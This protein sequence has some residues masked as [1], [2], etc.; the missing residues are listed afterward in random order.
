MPTRAGLAFVGLLLLLLLAGI[1]YQNSLAYGLCFLLASLFHTTI[2]HTFTNLLGL[3]VESLANPPVF[4]GEQ[5]GFALRLVASKRNFC[6][7][8]LSFTED[9]T[10][11]DVA[12]GGEQRLHL[13]LP[14]TQRGWL[15]PGRLKVETR[16][17][18]GLLK[19]WSWLDLDQRVLVYPQPIKGDWQ[20][21]LGITPDPGEGRSLH[22]LGVDDFHELRRYQA[23]DSLQRVHWKAYSK[24]QGLQV[25]EFAAQAGH[26]Q[27]LDFSALSGSVEQRLSVL[28]Q[29]VLDLE[30]AERSYGLRLPGFELAQGQGVAQQEAALKALALFGISD[31]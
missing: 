10:R 2:L 1:N 16:Y 24:G 25:K 30:A 17:P 9:Q 23:G 28:C 15:K 3:E 13:Y 22:A 8:D 5:A 19:A 20:Q 12:C 29:A 21:A 26:D 27:W 7:I 14:A 11:L 31:E 18:L 4:A 6:A